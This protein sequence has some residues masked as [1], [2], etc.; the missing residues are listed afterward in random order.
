MPG[1]ELVAGGDAA[2]GA[3]EGKA[4]FAPAGVIGGG[5]WGVGGVWEDEV[6]DG[7][8]GDGTAVG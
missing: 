2:D 4:A 8:V 1:E 7:E 5:A 6:A 3:E